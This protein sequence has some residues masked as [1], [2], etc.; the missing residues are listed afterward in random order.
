MKPLKLHLAYGLL[1][2]AAF[3]ACVSAENAIKTEIAI[4]KRCTLNSDCTDPNICV[5]GRCHAECQ[6]SADCSNGERCV[7]GEVAGTSVCQLAIDTNCAT[8]ADCVGSQVCGVDGECRDLCK[9]DTDC[10]EEQVCTQ[11]TCADASELDPAGELPENEENTGDGQP[12][13]YNSDCPGDL[14]C[15]NQL[16]GPECKGA[17]DCAVGFDCVESRCVAPTPECEENA[18]CQPGNLCTAGQCVPGC[19]QDPDCP[20]GN[21]C[22][23]GSCIPGC[24]DGGDCAFGEACVAGKC[25]ASCDTP[26]DCAN[27]GERCLAGLCQPGCDEPTDCGTGFYCA[28]DGSCAPGCASNTDCG[29]DETCLGNQCAVRLYDAQNTLFSRFAVASDKV[30]FLKGNELQVCSASGGCGSTPMKIGAI[31][32]PPQGFQEVQA[33]PAS[34]VAMSGKV[35]FANGTLQSNNFGAT[36][37]QV[38]FC[39]GNTCPADPTQTAR[40]TAKSQFLV[41]LALDRTETSPGAFTTYLYGQFTKQSGSPA[42]GAC[43]AETPDAKN[44]IVC[45]P[46]PLQLLDTADLGVDRGLVGIGDEMGYAASNGGDLLSVDLDACFQAQSCGTTTIAQLPGLPTAVEHGVGFVYWIEL[47]TNAL[48]AF[49]LATLTD[50]VLVPSGVVHVTTDANGGTSDLFVGTNEGIFRLAPP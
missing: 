32:P 24:N 20:D 1:I 18:D 9:A 21:V 27:P 30:W 33:G 37:T 40:I 34:V 38:F 23:G 5:F 7:K 36:Q 46:T 44:E 42:I 19:N 31:P 6:S 12:C 48:H 28:T 15:I 43:K 3:G 8:S 4:G 41:P 26:S 10:L 17:K 13:Q 49:E 39:D 16:C 25:V 2:A 14:L 29:I 47:G 22:S 35:Y 11:A 45:G 50:S